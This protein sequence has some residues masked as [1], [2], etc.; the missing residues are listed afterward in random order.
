MPLDCGPVRTV[1]RVKLGSHR[2]VSLAALLVVSVAA[3]GGCRSSQP[4][5]RATPVAQVT[6]AVT[7]EVT[8]AATPNSNS[9]APNDCVAPPATGGTAVHS[10]ALGVTVTL[11][12]GWSEDPADEGKRGLE[13]TFALKIGVEPNAASITAYPFPLNM[14]PHAAVALEISQPGAGNVVATGDCTIA[15]S[16]A[17]FFESTIQ[18]SL[19]PGITLV[20][21]GYG[22]YIAGPGGL[23]RLLVDLPS[24]NGIST[25]M[26][27]ASVMTDIRSIFGSWTWDQP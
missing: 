22:V 8:P 27:R 9:L 21:D 20:G 18:A 16:P 17:S 4:V 23:V 19:F 7:P 13:S 1:T 15:S 10:S 24:D 6:P 26:P 3:V 25:P 14:T 12:P 11:P 2:R 5:S